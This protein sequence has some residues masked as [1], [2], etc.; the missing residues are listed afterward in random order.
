MVVLPKTLKQRFDSQTMYAGDCIVWTGYCSSGYGQFMY[1]G[2][3]L[4]AHR[5]AYEL[6]YG[7][8][9]QKFHVD[10]ICRNHAC[11]NSAHLRAVSQRDNLHA[12]GSLSLSN[13]HRLKTHCVKG[14]ELAGDNLYVAKRKYGVNR[15][16]RI[17]KREAFLLFHA[18]KHRESMSEV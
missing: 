3:Q 10:H 2:K 18:R 9:P 12:P 11:V 8:I 1:A 7:A 14:H 6:T 5:V 16:C 4:W 15:Q 17:C 13:L